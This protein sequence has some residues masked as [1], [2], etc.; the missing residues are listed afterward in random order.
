MFI[1][2][3]KAAF[4]QFRVLILSEDRTIKNFVSCLFSEH[5]SRSQEEL[6]VTCE[7]VYFHSGCEFFRNMP[8]VQLH[9]FT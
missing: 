6:I 9:L 5:F 8:T 2:N 1:F 7:C 4:L 3:M